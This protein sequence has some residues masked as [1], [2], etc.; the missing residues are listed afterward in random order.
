MLLHGAALEDCSAL[1]M[2]RFS[3]FVWSRQAQFSNELVT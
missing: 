1:A 3:G 2:Q